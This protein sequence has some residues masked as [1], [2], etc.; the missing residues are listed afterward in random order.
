[1][2]AVQLAG[3]QHQVLGR[4]AQQALVEGPVA[5]GSSSWLVLQGTIWAEPSAVRRVDHRTPIRGQ[6]ARAAE[7]A[8]RRRRSGGHRSAPR[9]GGSPGLAQRPGNLRRGPGI[10]RPAGGPF[11]STA[12]CRGRSAGAYRLVCAKGRPFVFATGYTT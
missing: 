3:Q 2:R 4:H 1:M 10:L 11:R 9:R 12:G 8:G 7:G 6:Q 5:Q